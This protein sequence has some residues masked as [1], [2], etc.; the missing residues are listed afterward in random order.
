MDYCQPQAHWSV[1]GWALLERRGQKTDPWGGLSLHHHGLASSERAQPLPASKPASNL[2]PNGLLVWGFLV[3]LSLVIFS[4]GNASCLN[5]EKAMAPP[6]I[7]LP[8][9]SHGRRGLVGCS[10]WGHQESDTTEWLH[11]DFSLSCIG[12]G[13]FNPLQCSCLENPRDGGAWWAAVYGVA[14]RW[15]RLKRLGGSSSSCLN[16]SGWWFCVLVLVLCFDLASDQY[17]WEVKFIYNKIHPENGGVLW[18]L[19]NVCTHVTILQSR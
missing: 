14:Q 5:S 10:P 15:T 6:P 3:G 4:L 1:S 16:Y 13:N 9:K 12:E 18:I 2:T 17:F 8:G 7:L 19:T 11:F